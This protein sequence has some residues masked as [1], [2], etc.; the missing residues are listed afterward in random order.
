MLGC[1]PAT[2]ETTYWCSSGRAVDAG[3]T[4]RGAGAR[5]LLEDTGLSVAHVRALR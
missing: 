2:S 5:E 3:E 4:L 1:D